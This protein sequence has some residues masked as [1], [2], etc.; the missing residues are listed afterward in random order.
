MNLISTIS[1]DIL[2]LL[3]ESSVYVIFG[4]VIS[5]LIH[6]FL[7]PAFIARHL[8]KGRFLSV[9]KS[10]ILGIPLPLCSC[11][12]LP[13][14]VS[15]KKQGA[16]SGAVTAFLI[17][18]PETGVDSIAVTYA[19]LDPIMT[20]AR[21]VSAFFS[22]VFAGIFD[23]LFQK[24]KDSENMPPNL[25]CTIDNC[26]DG[27][28]CSPK[29]HA[30]H[31]SFIEKIKTGL[32]YAFTDVWGDMAGWFAFGLVLAGMITTFIPEETISRY[33]GGGFYSMLIML[34]IGIPLYICATASTPIAAA[35]ILKGLS[36]GAALVFLLAG[37][38][39]NVTS[40]TVL[41]GILGKR[42]TAIYLATISISAVISGLILDKIY[43]F[44]GI[45]PQAA[46]GHASEI[47][48]YWAKWA[49]A[50]ILTALS[51]KPIF[52][53]IRDRFMSKKTHEIHDDCTC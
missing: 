26:C 28:D 52:G 23:N 17:S 13:A 36:P 22:A 7:S 4:L 3:L 42:T 43:L 21:P 15:L 47:M 20:V 8:G 41:L 24:R 53:K 16:S 46:I 19:L 11:G 50:F 18:T 14:A 49:G 37:P 45:S 6:I 29:E 25:S 9:F 40:L 10:A 1:A 27:Q 5:G 48:P 34:A 38:A 2:R 32:I 39:T 44:S 51:I 33:L 31:H 35:L 12:V 30:R